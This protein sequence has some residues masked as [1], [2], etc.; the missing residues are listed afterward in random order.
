MEKSVCL[1]TSILIQYLRKRN[2][3]ET[4]LFTLSEA[5]NHFFLPTISH[6]EIIRGL[7][8]AHYKEW[9]ALLKGFTLLPFDEKASTTAA[10]I[11]Q[12]LRAKNQQIDTA[13]LL[14]AAI[15]LSNKLPL[16]TLN[17]KHFERVK[18]LNFR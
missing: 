12:R 4:R 9:T 7:T 3:E 5:Y 13:D 6:Y 14:I 1:D 17:K 2:K 10:K 15:A 18:G 11:Y 16:A 8:E